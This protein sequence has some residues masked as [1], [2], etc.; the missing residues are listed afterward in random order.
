MRKPDGACVK[1]GESPESESLPNRGAWRTYGVPAPNG[2]E[3]VIAGITRDSNVRM[4][5][6]F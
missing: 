1:T 6:N 2:R 4:I 5:E 3:L